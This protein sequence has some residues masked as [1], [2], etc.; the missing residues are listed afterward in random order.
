MVVACGP[1]GE[2]QIYEEAPC[3]VVEVVSPGTEAVDR[4][5]KLLACKR[6]STVEAYLIAEGEKARVE[7]HWRDEQ[8]TWWRLEDI[9]PGTSSG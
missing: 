8:G 3:L 5:E 6:L 1:E 7:R 2:D 9:D 4:R